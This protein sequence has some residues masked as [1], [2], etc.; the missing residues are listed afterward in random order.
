MKCRDKKFLN[1]AGST[2]LHKT[3]PHVCC[4]QSSDQKETAQRSSG[5]EN[6]DNRWLTTYIHVENCLCSFFFRV[7]VTIFF[8]KREKGR[9]KAEIHPFCFRVLSGQIRNT[10]PNGNVCTQLLDR[11]G[12]STHNIILFVA[13][14]LEY[15]LSCC[16]FAVKISTNIVTCRETKTF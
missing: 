14:F 10:F 15:E 5:Q 2:V 11:S 9:V 16:S 4:G 1:C 13:S 12:H 3:W 6:E 7:V 8:N